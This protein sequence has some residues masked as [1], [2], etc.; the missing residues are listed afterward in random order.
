MT[1]D[2]LSYKRATTVSLTGLALQ[3]L[4]FI[5]LLI[6]GLLARDDAAVTGALAIG[7]GSVIWISLAIVFHQHPPAL[8]RRRYSER[9]ARTSSPM[10][11]ASRSSTS[12]SCPSSASFWASSMPPLDY[13]V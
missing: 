6:Y 11:G 10:P 12:S 9:R 3:V 7:L 5:V 13:C 2:H 8:R 4:L 1:A